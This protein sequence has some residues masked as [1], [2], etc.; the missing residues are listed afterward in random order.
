MYSLVNVRY[1]TAPPG[2]ATAD[3]E[4][5]SQRQ[6]A[7]LLQGWL[8]QR[9]SVTKHDSDQAHICVEQ[10]AFYFGDRCT[11]YCISTQSLMLLLCSVPPLELHY[12]KS[13]ALCQS[14]LLKPTRGCACALFNCR[15]RQRQQGQY[16]MAADVHI[17]HI[18]IMCKNTPTPNPAGC[19]RV[20]PHA[21]VMLLLCHC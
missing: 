4:S 13:Q 17:G 21:A 18:P 20:G 15:S 11:A 19:G 9:V 1:G 10:R 12:R 8:K 3:K 6:H 5:I 7:Q 14:Y 16:A 2:P